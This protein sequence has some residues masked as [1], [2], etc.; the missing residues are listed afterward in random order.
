MYA[1]DPLEALRRLR[2]ARCGRAVGWPSRC[3]ERRTRS[4][5][6]APVPVIVECPRDRTPLRRT[7]LRPRRARHAGGVRVPTSRLCRGLSPAPPSPSTSWP[8]AKPAPAGSGTRAPH[9]RAGR[10]ASPRAVQDEVWARV[11]GA[12]SPFEEEDGHVRL[13][14]TA[15]WV[16]ATNPWLGGWLEELDQAVLLDLLGAGA[17]QVVDDHDLAGRLVGGQRSSPRRR[18]RRASVLPRARAA[19]RRRGPRP[20][21]VGEPHDG[22]LEHVGVLLEHRLDLDGEHRVP[23]DLD[24]VLLRPANTTEPSG[25]RRAR[26]PVRSHPSSVSAASVAA[27]RRSSP[28]ARPGP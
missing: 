24:H 23:A 21:L 8:T 2:R 5:S 10:R 1:S 17:G 19:R 13:P 14:C 22:R 6:S 26:S 7:G 12:W 15:V 27:R 11:T 3:G 4:P 20:S 25:P 28:A 9:L 18:G 16:A